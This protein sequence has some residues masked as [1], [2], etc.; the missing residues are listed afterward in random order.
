M[1]SISRTGFAHPGNL[2]RGGQ[3]HRLPGQDRNGMAGY[4]ISRIIYTY[5]YNSGYNYMAFDGTAGQPGHRP[6]CFLPHLSEKNV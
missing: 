6:V 3:P 5:I 1:G 4:Q 2:C